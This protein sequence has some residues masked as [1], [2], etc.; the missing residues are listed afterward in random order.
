MVDNKLNLTIIQPDIIWGDIDANLKHLDILISGNNSPSD[1]ILLPEMFSTGF[2]MDTKNLAETNQGKAF[3][4]M[5]NISAKFKTAI[6]GSIIYTE[7]NKFFNRLYW[8]NP[9]GE[10][11]SYDKRHLFGMGREDE[12]YEPGNKRL[13]LQYKGWRICPLICY[14][15]RFPVWSR[16][17]N[18]Y[19]LLVYVANWPAARNQVWNILLR[20]RAIENQCF[21]A[22]VNRVGR[23]G[24][25]IHYIGESCVIH[26]KGYLSKGIH[27]PIEQALNY[28]IDLQ[29]LLDFRKKFPVL[30]DADNISDILK[31][32][33][34]RKE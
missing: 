20:A 26:P 21:V 4:W 7:N 6:T 33:E 3:K 29:E 28:T 9:D 5:L 12:F 13:I 22:G 15:L 25:N 14:D 11:Y 8:I 23:D 34:L 19:D 18:D 27:E 17:N 30:N 1:V 24:E 32:N 10:S 31:M 2:S 16:N